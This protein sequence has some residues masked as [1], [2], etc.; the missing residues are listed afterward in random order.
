[1]NVFC[2]TGLDFDFKKHLLPNIGNKYNLIFILQ[3]RRCKLAFCKQRCFTT[4]VRH[5]LFYQTS[6]NE[7]GIKLCQI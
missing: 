7:G 1:M 4:V 6:K 3:Q 2:D 5:L